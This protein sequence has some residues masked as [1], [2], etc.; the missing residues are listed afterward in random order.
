VQDIT[1]AHFN[2]RT[3]IGPA[4]TVGSWHI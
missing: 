2:L 4:T 1:G 3:L